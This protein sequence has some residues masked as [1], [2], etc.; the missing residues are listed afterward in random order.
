MSANGRLATRAICASSI[1]VK[2]L[3]WA[4]GRAALTAR[5]SSK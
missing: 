5:S 2:A 1:I 3:T 4:S